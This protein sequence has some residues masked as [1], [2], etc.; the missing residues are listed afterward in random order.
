MPKRTSIHHARMLAAAKRQMEE[1][2]VEF[3]SPSKQWADNGHDDGFYQGERSDYKAQR[4]KVN[5]IK[6][7]A[8]QNVRSDIAKSRQERETDPQGRDWMPMPEGTLVEFV[9]ND[10]RFTGERFKKG[11]L[12][13][14]VKEFETDGKRWVEVLV[15]AQVIVVKKSAL[16]EL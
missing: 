10:A 2:G 12:A 15:G 6:R 7:W 14:V 3:T 5:K 13:T 4:N 11:A 8:A 1:A 9:K 16:K